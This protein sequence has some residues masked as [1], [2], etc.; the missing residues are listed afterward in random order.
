MVGW[1]MKRWKIVLGMTVVA[2]ALGC[3]S[4]NPTD[5]SK[6]IQSEKAKYNKAEIEDI[7]VVSVVKMNIP[8]SE[9]M[10]P[11]QEKMLREMTGE[12]ELKTWKKG[13]KYRVDAGNVVTIFD[14]KDSWFFAPFIGKQKASADEG[15]Q[16][17]PEWHWWDLI[18]EDAKIVGTEKV[19]KRECWV[20]ESQFEEIPGKIWLDKNDMVLMKHE[21]GVE[22]EPKTIV[23]M[24][25]SDH[26]KV[27]GDWKIP[28]KTVT[29]LDGELTATMLVQSIEINQGLSD[30]L[31]DPDKVEVK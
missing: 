18:S 27:K 5:M 20:I 30:D 14:G 15:K 19:D 1:T 26:R 17:H 23:S 24:V 4:G 29:Y 31:F 25:Y 9:G 7:A 21:Y 11:E 13:E 12:Q 8:K 2:L 16:V 6:I 22:G 28:Y 10:T 3:S